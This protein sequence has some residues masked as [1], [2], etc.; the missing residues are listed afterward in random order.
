[1]CCAKGAIFHFFWLNLLLMVLMPLWGITFSLLAFM[2]TVLY[3]RIY[4]SSIYSTILNNVQHIH[5]LLSC[6]F[7]FLLFFDIFYNNFFFCFLFGIINC[8]CSSLITCWLFHVCLERFQQE[9]LNSKLLS[10]FFNF[11]S[12]F[13]DE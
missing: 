7:L 4:R 3:T 6:S 2:Y 12:Q 9:I 5:T 1:M 8:C 10:R 13:Q 11:F